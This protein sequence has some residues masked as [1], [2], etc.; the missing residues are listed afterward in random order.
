MTAGAKGQAPGAH[1]APSSLE[2]RAGRDAISAGRDVRVAYHSYGQAESRST[3]QKASF[4]QIRKF[5]PATDRI[6]RA[7]EEELLFD[8]A[9]IALL[10]KGRLATGVF[11]PIGVVIF[12]LMLIILLL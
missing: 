12:A 4:G 3:I 7:A 6:M 10:C 5:D 8:R 11:I 2:Q 9:R 1:P